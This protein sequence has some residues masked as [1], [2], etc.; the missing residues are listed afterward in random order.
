MFLQS[1]EAGNADLLQ[2]MIRGVLVHTCMTWSRYQSAR[3]LHVPVRRTIEAKMEGS[4]NVVHVNSCT[5]RF[6]TNTDL[7]ILQVVLQ[8]P[9]IS[10]YANS[11]R[12]ANEIRQVFLCS[13]DML[14]MMY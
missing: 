2:L 3:S 1:T 14:D 6:W 5:Q 9:Q 4:V 7:A 12:L 13:F 11:Y 10:H 8:Q